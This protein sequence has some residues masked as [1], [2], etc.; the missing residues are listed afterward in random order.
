MRKIAAGAVLAG[1][2]IA[3]IPNL[4]SGAASR[5]CAMKASRLLLANSAA[6]VYV[7]TGRDRTVTYACLEP[8]RR[9]QVLGEGDI[10]GEGVQTI[11]S[12]IV[13]ERRLVAWQQTFAQKGNLIGQP[14]I[15]VSDLA[16]GRTVRT[17]VGGS[18]IASDLALTPTGTVAWI[19]G[20]DSERRVMAYDGTELRQLDAG[21]GIDPFSLAVADAGPSPAEAPRPVVY[22][23]RGDAPRMAELP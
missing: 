9:R 16:T 23:R 15:V 22:W 20:T 12:L 14:R 6:H 11:A 13:L 3:I 1:L 18:E 8:Q 10:G 7:R 2:L 4:S 5:P 19:V 21:S 17:E